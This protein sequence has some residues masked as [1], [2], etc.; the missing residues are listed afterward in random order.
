[1]LYLGLAMKM[2][3][4]FSMANCECHNSRW[5]VDRPPK[6]AV[7]F[8][9]ILQAGYPAGDLTI[10]WSQSPVFWGSTD[11][12]QIRCSSVS[13]LTWS[14]G[15]SLPSANSSVSA[16][17]SW[18]LPWFRKKTIGIFGSSPP[19]KWW[20]VHMLNYMSMRINRP[21]SIYPIC[22]PFY[23]HYIPPKWHS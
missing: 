23:P 5:W 2:A 14:R 19:F 9:W 18:E 13:S 1:M 22:M 11:S 20:F 6:D 17:F 15:T 8:L 4:W 16:W 10:N 12:P 3:W 21:G 7:L